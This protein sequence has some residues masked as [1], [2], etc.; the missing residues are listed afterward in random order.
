V[1]YQVKPINAKWFE[2]KIL[3]G[4]DLAPIV[5]QWE[6]GQP[7][8]PPGPPWQQPGQPWPPQGQP[9]QQ[10]GQPW[11]QPGQPWPQHRQPGQ[12]LGAAGRACLEQMTR[13]CARLVQIRD[14]ICSP[15][16]DCHL[17]QALASP[18]REA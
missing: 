2:V 13:V 11:R 18:A 16:L 15:R 12:P 9:W 17:F 6:A 1:T 14:I 4:L 5:I 10:P 3:R 7:W 8:Q